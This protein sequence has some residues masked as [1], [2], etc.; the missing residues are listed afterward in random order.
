[1]RVTVSSVRCPDEVIE[2]R[3]SARHGMMLSHINYS[4]LDRVRRSRARLN[5]VHSDAH[6]IGLFEVSLAPDSVQRGSKYA[7]ST[8]FGDSRAANPERAAMIAAVRGQVS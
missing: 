3:E 5:D 6:R 4:L 2:I 1:M 7:A 8:S